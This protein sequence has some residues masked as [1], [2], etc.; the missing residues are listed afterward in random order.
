[1]QNGFDG[2]KQ[3]FWKWVKKS[4]QSGIKNKNDEI[5]QDEAAVKEQQKE[6]F[7][8][9]TV[10]TGIVTNAAIIVTILWPAV[11][12]KLKN[13]DTLKTNKKKKQYKFSRRGRNTGL[14]N[15]ERSI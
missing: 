6:Y 15:L 5:I 2:S 13:E 10:K 11:R 1:M 12:I 8:G 14:D 3:L 9:L 7:R 4:Q